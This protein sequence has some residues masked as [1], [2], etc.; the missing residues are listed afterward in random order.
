MAT[1]R[2]YGVDGRLIRTIDQGNKPTG[3][4]TVL[5]DTHELTG[6]TYFVV[7]ETPEKRMSAKLVVVR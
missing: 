5:V 6:G 7:L 4:H 1:I 3:S 2:L